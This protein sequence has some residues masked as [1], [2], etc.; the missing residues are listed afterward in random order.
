MTVVVRAP[1]APK[2]P[3]LKHYTVGANLT[4]LD[5]AP[6]S[7]SP[8][9]YHVTTLNNIPAG[10]AQNER[11]GVKIQPKRLKLRVKCAVD[12]NSDASSTNIVADAHTFRVVVY[13]DRS[14]NGA[15]TTWAT[16]MQT[17]PTNSGQ[18]YAYQNPWF[19]NRRF[20]VLSDRFVTVKPSMV[21]YDGTNFHAYGNNKFLNFDLALSHETWYSDSTNNMTAIQQGNLGFFVCADAS[22]TTYTTMKFSYRANL[23]YQDY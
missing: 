11:S 13:L 22:S 8:A 1:S 9:L 23:R 7:T 15:A 18:L 12:P 5:T 19:Q 2:N 21:V 16:L 14:P 6:S 20:K 10:D 17:T 4:S 3:E